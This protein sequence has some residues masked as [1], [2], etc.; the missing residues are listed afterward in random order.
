MEHQ[1]NSFSGVPAWMNALA[2]HE[3]ERVWNSDSTDDRT[4]PVISGNGERRQL[5]ADCRDRGQ[6][7]V[8]AAR[9]G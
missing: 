3:A 7:N 1:T 6:P 8:T 9:S 2:I 4:I 5:L